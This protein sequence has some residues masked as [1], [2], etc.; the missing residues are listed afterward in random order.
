MSPRRPRSRV[1]RAA[2]CASIALACVSGAV[3]CGGFSA[4][5]APVESEAGAETSATDTS[6]ATD[7]SDGAV[8][9]AADAADAL[10]PDPCA[11]DAGFLHCESFETASSCD[12]PWIPSS[13]S[14]TLMTGDGHSGTGFCRYCATGTNT[15]VRQTFSFSMVS[16]YALSVWVRQ[17]GT[18]PDAAGPAV[19]GAGIFVFPDASP[20]VAPLVNSTQFTAL[21]TTEWRRIQS[22]V[23]GAAAGVREVVTIAP[24]PSA[25]SIGECFDVDDVTIASK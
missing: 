3:A 12:L 20:G 22:S 5:D 25:N 10:A 17:S 1:L 23:I 18:A 19:A 15:E 6:V 4:T 11:Q 13:A 2:A 9:D 21:S 14:W 7:A 16:G 24:N 8:I